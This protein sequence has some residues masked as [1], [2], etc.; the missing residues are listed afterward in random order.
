MDSDFT[1]GK[2][3]WFKVELVEP[4]D[5]LNQKL[6]SDK[7]GLYYSVKFEGDATM[8]L[9][10]A[11]TA[12]IASEIVYGHLEKT[13][14]GKSTRFHKAKKDDIPPS[15]ESTVTTNMKAEPLGKVG[16]T[17]DYWSD[18]DKAIRAQWAIG[19]AK[20]WAMGNALSFDEIEPVAADFFAM[21]GR[22]KKGSQQGEKKQ[23]T[24]LEVPDGEITYED[25]P[26]FAQDQV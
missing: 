9:W 25:I 18:K 10:Q 20:D 7:F 22:V 15:N 26:D 23:D 13:T 12:P 5:F 3:G 21:V 24:V 1:L 19:Q 8:H 4:N 2:M 14:S 6:E 17:E 16:Q 11:K